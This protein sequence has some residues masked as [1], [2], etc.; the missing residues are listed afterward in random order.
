[1]TFNQN[2]INTKKGIPSNENMFR[3]KPSNKKKKTIQNTQK[4]K[5]KLNFQRYEHLTDDWV[6]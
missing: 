5:L 6:V 4:L 2:P 1:M 3:L